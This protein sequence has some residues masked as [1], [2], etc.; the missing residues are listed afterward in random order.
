[1]IIVTVGQAG[2]CGEALFRE[3]VSPKEITGIFLWVGPGIAL[4]LFCC[5]PGAPSEGPG[6]FAPGCLPK[7][8]IFYEI[9]PPLAEQSHYSSLA[10]P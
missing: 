7:Y 5:L 8:Q 4:F 3:A 10:A 9:E 6:I 2:P 1:M